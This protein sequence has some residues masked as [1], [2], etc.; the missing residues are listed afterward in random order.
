MAARMQF[1]LPFMD[2]KAAP[3]EET[4]GQRI[5]RLME[6][7]RLNQSDVA[8]AL[9]CSRMTVSQWVND[10]SQPTPSNLLWLADLLHTDAHY[11]VFGAEGDTSGPSG[12]S[13]APSGVFRAPFRRRRT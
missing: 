5:S 2:D 6:S 11:L 8:R 10:I 4:M 1:S 13:G 9:K 12:P 7:H 3:T